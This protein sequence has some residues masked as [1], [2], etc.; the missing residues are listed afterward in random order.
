MIE[1]DARPDT[2]DRVTLLR[3]LTG[4]RKGDF[5]VR[6]PVEWTGVDGKIA[7]AFNEVVERNQRMARELEALSD[8]MI[9]CRVV[10]DSPHRNQEK[11][12]TYAVKIE[13]QVPGPDIVVSREPVADW[14]LALNEAFDVARRRLK[15]HEARIRGD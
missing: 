4:F 15:E 7:E 5:T 12:K 2:L 13:M 9:G 6:L 8:R 3:A 14:R 11:G 1:H 10:I